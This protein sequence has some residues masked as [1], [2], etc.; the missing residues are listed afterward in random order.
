[1]KSASLYADLPSFPSLSSI[2]GNSL[3]PYLVVVL[4]NTTVYL[5]ELTVGFESNIKVNSDRKAHP[6]LT[7]LRTDYTNINFVYFSISAFGIFVTS[8][9]TFLQMLKDLNFNRNLTRHII[10]NASDIAIRCKS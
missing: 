2:T 5:L 6:L 8:S 7:N 9:N 1:M 10:M 4:D 3:R